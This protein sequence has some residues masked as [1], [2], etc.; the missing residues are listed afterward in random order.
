ME[1][2][3]DACQVMSEGDRVHDDSVE[4]DAFNARLDEPVVRDMEARLPLTHVRERGR[5]RGDDGGR[6]L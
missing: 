6:G 3:D 5:E 1:H 4:R 2:D